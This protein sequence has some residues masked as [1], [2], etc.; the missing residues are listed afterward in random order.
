MKKSLAI[1]LSASMLLAGCAVSRSTTQP[2]VAHMPK[3]SASVHVATSAKDDPLAK[4]F[5]A[6]PVKFLEGGLEWYDGHVKDYTVTLYKLERMDPKAADFLPEQKILAKFKE[7]PYSVFMQTVKNPRGAEKAL[8]IEGKWN[9]RL[10]AR[11]GGFLP[12]TV[13]TDT[14]GALARQN[15]LRFIDQFGFKRS[16]LTI[17]NSLRTAWAE[18]IVRLEVVGP[19]KIGG[20]DVLIIDSWITEAKATGRFEFPHIRVYLDR[21]WQLPLE[22]DIWD[23][24]GVERGRYRMEDVKFN[25]GLTDEDFTLKANGM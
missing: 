17:T 6:D 18:K 12:L 15:T 21:E 13:E 25:V 19:G 20:R 5:A 23:P 7:N 10:K 4:Q 3:P 14:R 22:V 2:G 9:G 11:T 24:S 8:Y 1:V 16:L